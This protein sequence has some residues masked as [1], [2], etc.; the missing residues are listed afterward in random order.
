MCKS[1]SLN[2]EVVLEN[3]NVHRDLFYFILEEFQLDQNEDD[4]C[5]MIK[6]KLKLKELQS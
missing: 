1:N 4:E 3:P 2:A 6:I 5:L